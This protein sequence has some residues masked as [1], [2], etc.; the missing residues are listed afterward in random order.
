MAPSFRS[1]FCY[2]AGVH[3]LSPS[4]MKIEK[5]P[6]G[7]VSS[8]AY[9]FFSEGIRG[10]YEIRVNFS[11][12]DQDLYNLGFGVWNSDR[13]AIDDSIET[14][15]GDMDRILTTVS[16]ITFQFLES[17]SQAIVLATGSS[18]IR[19]RK[20]QIGIGQ[21]LDSLNSRYFIKGFIA[22][23]DKHGI[24]SGVYPNWAGTWSDF[25]KGRNYDAFL[26][27]LR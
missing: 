8:N 7:Q 3:T 12:L 19:T 14:R 4:L 27:Y 25:E 24:I 16:Q 22:D 20:Y 18:T 13:E 21:N 11:Y 15:N 17:N 5:Y 23:R 26:I 1:H 9:Q 10:R 6:S 2:I